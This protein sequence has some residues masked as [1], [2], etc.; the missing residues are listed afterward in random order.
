MPRERDGSFTPEPWTKL[1]GPLFGV[2][3][4]VTEQEKER[5]RILREVVAL[6]ILH[7]A[8]TAD[9]NIRENRRPV[10]T[11]KALGQSSAYA[12]VICRLF[13]DRVIPDDVTVQMWRAARTLGVIVDNPASGRFYGWPKAA[14]E[15]TLADAVGLADLALRGDWPT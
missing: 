9:R 4:P 15:Y 5:H 10:F 14:R 6:Y 11:G 7:I 13:D 2:Q 12:R 3:Q 1:A 8:R